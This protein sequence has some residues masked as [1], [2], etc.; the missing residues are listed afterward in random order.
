VARKG[1]DKLSWDVMNYL[2]E[3]RGDEGEGLEND[4]FPAD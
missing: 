3:Q 2:E 4:E 1:L